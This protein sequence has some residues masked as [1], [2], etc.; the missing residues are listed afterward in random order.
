MYN[1]RFLSHLLLD[2]IITLME[3]IVLSTLVKYKKISLTNI[4]GGPKKDRLF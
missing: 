3:V 4:L 1:V 2:D